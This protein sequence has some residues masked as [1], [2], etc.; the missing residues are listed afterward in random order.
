[1]GARQEILARNLFSDQVSGL[2][3]LCE[4]PRIKGASRS[5]A[6]R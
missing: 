6:E 4:I 3:E 2:R 5:A 1:M